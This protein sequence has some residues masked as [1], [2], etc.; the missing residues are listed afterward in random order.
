[1]SHLESLEKRAKITVDWSDF[2]KKC[3]LGA[4]GNNG[5]NTANLFDCLHIPVDV[6]HGLRLGEADRNSLT[7]MK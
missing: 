6:R 2:T 4:E 7:G 5:N 1:M 3:L